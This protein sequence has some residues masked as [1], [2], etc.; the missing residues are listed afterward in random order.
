M[1]SI[2][3][4]E[5]ALKHN[6][7]NDVLVGV[8]HMTS[9]LAFPSMAFESCLIFPA[10]Y[11]TTGGLR[12]P[13]RASFPVILADNGDPRELSERCVSRVNWAWQTTG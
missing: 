5:M 12:G 10:R 2:N 9:K 7:F 4:K 1:V 11:G 8:V 3:F 13:C 6:G